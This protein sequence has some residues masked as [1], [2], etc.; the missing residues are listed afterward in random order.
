MKITDN[1]Q[2][3]ELNPPW[4]L[5]HKW[6][7]DDDENISVNVVCY[8]KPDGTEFCVGYY[9]EGDWLNTKGEAIQCYYWHYAL[10]LDGKFVKVTE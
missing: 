7:A 10:H 2:T 4:V 3:V 8:I 5:P 6:S 9:E 1:I